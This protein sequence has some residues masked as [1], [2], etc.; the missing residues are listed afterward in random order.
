MN[1]RLFQ[2]NAT[3]THSKPN[4]RKR[5]IDI[6]QGLQNHKTGH[7]VK[8]KEPWDERGMYNVSRGCYRL[9]VAQYI[10]YDIDYSIDS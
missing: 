6:K 2:Q 9:N 4:A 5:G 8:Q 7:L 10:F 1:S 3:Y